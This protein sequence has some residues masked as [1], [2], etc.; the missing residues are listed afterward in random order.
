MNNKTISKDDEYYMS[1]AL[2]EAKLAYSEDEIPVGA[3]LVFENEVIYTDH[4]RTNQSHNPLFHAEKLVLDK[5]LS[6][7]IKYL[8]DY[9]L[10]VTL[11]PC[12]MCAGM[13]IW[14][15]LG[16][17]V[18]A[19]YDSKA[20]CVGSIYNVLNEASFNHHPQIT[21]GVLAQD[22]GDLLSEFFKNKR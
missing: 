10:Y 20:G 16:R 18:F 11:E 6:A 14:C 12:V 1:L 17:L 2:Q 3:V 19:A 7:C 5:A 21:G 13:M 8:Y 15:R 9:T 22:S 4:N